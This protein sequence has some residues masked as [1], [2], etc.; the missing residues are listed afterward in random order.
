MIYIGMVIIA[1]VTR[2]NGQI[3]DMKINRKVVAYSPLIVL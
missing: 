1:E 3:A 2:A